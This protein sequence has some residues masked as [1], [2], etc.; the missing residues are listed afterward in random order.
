[1]VDVQVGDIVELKKG[2]PC[3]TNR[4]R[5]YR[6][7]ADIGLRCTGCDRMQMIPRAKFNK[8]FKRKLHE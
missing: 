7:G 2:H 1:M 4:W 8:A 6:I 3:G 5:V